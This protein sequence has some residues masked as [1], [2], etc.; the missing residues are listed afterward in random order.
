MMSIWTSLKSCS[1]SGWDGTNNKFRPLEN[2]LGDRRRNRWH[3][4]D[5]T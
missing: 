3:A 1:G 2:T 5:S 4:G